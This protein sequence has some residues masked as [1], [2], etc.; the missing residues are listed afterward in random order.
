MEPLRGG[1]LVNGLPP[2][3]KKI[4]NGTDCSAAAWAFKWL[5][6]QKEIMTVLS[7]M[8]SLEMLEEN[9]KTASNAYVGM[10][11]DDDNKMFESIVK[12]INSRMKVG[13]TGCRYCMPCPSGVDIPGIFSA[14]NRKYTEGRIAGYKD[15][16]M[17]TGLR[18]D[19]TGASVCIGC[20]KCE[21]HCPQAIEIRKE[22]K[23]AQRELE[24]PIYKIGKAIIGRFMKY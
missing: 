4:I 11:T 5:Y 24:T 8:N 16:I 2:E 3:A 12:A 14:Y 15:Y 22:L 19:N 17:T 9:V 18:K 23:N 10:L 7:G 21:R 1:R 13:C 6:N 20:G